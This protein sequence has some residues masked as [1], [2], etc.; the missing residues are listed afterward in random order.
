MKCQIECCIDEWAT[1]IKTDVPFYSSDYRS[2]FDDH[3]D[4]IEEF[5]K[6]TKKYQLLDNLLVRIY[7]RGRSV[8]ILF[9]LPD[10]DL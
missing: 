5:G 10:V 6:H 9:R 8:V 7:N 3:L 4:S 1:G 2:V